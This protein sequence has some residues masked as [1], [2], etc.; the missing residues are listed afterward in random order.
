MRLS[1]CAIHFMQKTYTVKPPKLINRQVIGA[2]FHHNLQHPYLCW[3]KGLNKDAWHVTILMLLLLC[4][5]KSIRKTV[6]SYDVSFRNILCVTVQIAIFIVMTL[7]VCGSIMA[8]HLSDCLI[9]EVSHSTITTEITLI[10]TTVYVALLKCCLHKPI[11][12]LVAL[13]IAFVYIY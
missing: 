6:C 1:D 2:S 12:M 8:V 5:V 11:I 4:I 7:A 3:H 10:Q 13:V 9:I